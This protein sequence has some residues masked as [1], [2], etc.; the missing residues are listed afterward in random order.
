MAQDALRRD[1]LDVFT[2]FFN[3]SRRWDRAMESLQADRGQQMLLPA[4]DV[5]EGEDH[6]LISTELPGTPKDAVQITIENGVLVIS[7]EKKRAT[8]DKPK[9]VH[10]VER[11]FGSFHRSVTLPRQLDSSK[12]E[13]TFE[14]G[15]LT[16]RIPRSEEAKPKQLEIK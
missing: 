13:A 10:L 14:D 15:V 3:I 9:D 5:V 4:M 8:E 11:N 7:G 12:A 16:I 1:S 6:L 2:P